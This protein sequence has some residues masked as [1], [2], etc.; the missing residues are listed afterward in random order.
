[1]VNQNFPSLASRTRNCE[2]LDLRLVSDSDS[3]SLYMV[4]QV[5]VSDSNFSSFLVSS[6]EWTILGAFYVWELETRTRNTE[7]LGLRLVSVSDSVSFYTVEP[8]SVSVSES[9]YAAKGSQIRNR[10][11]KIRTRETLREWGGYLA[12]CSLDLMPRH[13]KP[14]CHL[15]YFC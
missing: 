12:L 2:S 3:V 14:Y 7:S 15:K 4:G 8:D 1:M 10:D 11:S 5:S 6:L 9:I 13:P